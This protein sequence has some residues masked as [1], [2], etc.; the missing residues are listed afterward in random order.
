MYMYMGERVIARI[1]QTPRVLYLSICMCN[2][3]GE[4]TLI[5]CVNIAMGV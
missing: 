4:F 3:S 2:K 1:A 5:Q